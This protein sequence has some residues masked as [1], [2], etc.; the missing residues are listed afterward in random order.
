MGS[1]SAAKGT[2]GVLGKGGNGWREEE[3]KGIVEVEGGGWEG[4]GG[5]WWEV[6]GKFW[7]AGWRET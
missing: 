2:E 6:V 7:K 4:L 3:L 5:G 1:E